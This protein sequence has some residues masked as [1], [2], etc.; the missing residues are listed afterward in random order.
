MKFGFDFTSASA[1]RIAFAA[2]FFLAGLL[3]LF[4][5]PSYSFWK[6]SIVVMEGGHFAVLPL[7]LL[8]FWSFKSA[9]S[10][11]AAAVL[12][13][14]A[15]LLFAFT[16]LRAL[17]VAAA[18]D[19]EF[20]A[21]W[22]TDLRPPSGS[23]QRERT[24]S[25]VDLFNGIPVPTDSP[26][27]LVYARK[28]DRDLR[29]DFYPAAGVPVARDPAAKRGARPAPCVIVVHGGGW[30]GGARSQLA[31]LN[32]FLAAEG[33]AVATLEY[34][35]AP[36][37]LYPAPVEDVTDAIAFL[38]AHSADLGIDSS[39]FALLG[40]SAGGQIALQAAYTLKDPGIKGVIAFY[41]P[42]DMV[43][44]YGLPTNPLIMD[45][46]LLMRQYLGGG[47]EDHPE[48]YVASSPIE[49]L[50]KSS[51]PTL[52]LHGRPD[53]LVSFRHTVHLRA[54]MEALGTRHFVVEVPWG[55]HGFDYV[56]RGPGS[57]ISLYFIERF[58]AGVLP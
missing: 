57:Q 46:R 28:S 35:L 55:A 58:L 27:T 30:D 19:K 22:G 37:H 26:R 14:V 50:D 21:K 12:F 6:L 34:R 52:L 45:S 2:A 31:D 41:A 3:A 49:H 1:L 29:L 16:S 20:A 24:L 53:V 18:L 43:F 38:R 44:G 10:G 47:Y 15:A 51:P 8:A 9:G 36:E 5:P 7:L 11:R 54:K 4:K 39:R 17:G 40:R 42:A 25:W 33:Y 48:N 13:L 56:F 23:F 32:A